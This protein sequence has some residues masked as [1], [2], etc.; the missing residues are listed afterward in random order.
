MTGLVL[1][2]VS[3]KHEEYMSIQHKRGDG[4]CTTVNQ[5][6]SFHDTRHVSIYLRMRKAF[7]SIFLCDVPP[8]ETTDRSYR[9]EGF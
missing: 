2:S 9:P 6:F 5:V 7:F 8:Q 1:V 4:Y 3:E